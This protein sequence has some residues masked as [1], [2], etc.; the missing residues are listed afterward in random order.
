M[1]KI[2]ASKLKLLRKIKKRSQEDVADYLNIS[3][4]SYARMESGESHSW[5]NHIL[6]LCE[7]FE[8]LPE[9]L[10]KMENLEENSD[11]VFPKT[12]SQKAIDEYESKIEDLKIEIEDLK[13]NTN[14]KD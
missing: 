1:N 13:K 11:F 5:A 7:F 12:F 10:V 6:K 2:V 8:I 3:Q 14:N 4:S 9:D